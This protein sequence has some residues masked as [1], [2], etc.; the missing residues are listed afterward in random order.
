[1][2]GKKFTISQELAEKEAKHLGTHKAAA[3]VPDHYIKDFAPVLKKAKM[4][5]CHRIKKQWRTFH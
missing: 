1:M 3:S 2:G 4:G 5:P